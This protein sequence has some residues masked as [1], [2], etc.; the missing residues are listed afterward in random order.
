MCA[1]AMEH[2]GC[3]QPYTHDAERF[4]TLLLFGVPRVFRGEVKGCITRFCDRLADL[5]ELYFCRIVGKSGAVGCEIDG[6]FRN[7]VE[8]FERAFHSGGT[9]R[10]GHAVYAEFSAFADLRGDKAVAGVFH[11]GLQLNEIYFRLV[12]LHAQGLGCKV[13]FRCGNAFQLRYCALDVRRTRGAGHAG[14]F[15]RSFNHRFLL[16]RSIR[17]RNATNQDPE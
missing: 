12:K 10:A 5:R 8:L 15:V 9:A 14:D 13:D 16:N 11:S 3:K 6:S 1:M 2:G 4:F 17:R 7:A